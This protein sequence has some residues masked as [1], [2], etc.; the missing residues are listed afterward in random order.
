MAKDPLSQISNVNAGLD[1]TI[2]KVTTLE[3]L[4]RKLGGIATKSLDSINRMMMPSVGTGPGM[5][6]PT[7]NLAMAQV[8]HLLLVQ[9]TQCLGFIQSQVLQELLEFNLG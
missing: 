4:S 7:L 3:S 9:L 5:G 8:V 1:Q 2:K 6:L